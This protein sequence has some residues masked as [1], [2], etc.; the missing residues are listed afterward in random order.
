MNKIER[1][2]AVL[3]GQTPDRLPCTFWYH[4]G[5]QFGP[6]E[7]FARV[8]LSFYEAFDVDILKLMNDYHYRCPAGLDV[9]K[10]AHDLEQVVYIDPETSIAHEQLKAIEIIS[11][12]LQRKA[13]FIDTVFDPWQQ[14][15][16]HVTGEYTHELTQTCPD[17]LLAAL[18]R[19]TDYVIAYAK[20]SLQRGSAGIF[21]A[22]QAS[23]NLVPGGREVY[24]RFIEPQAMRIMDELEG[25]GKLNTLHMCG[26]EIYTENIPQYKFPVLSWADRLPA[27]PSIAEMKQLSSAVM[28][29]GLDQTKLN[30]KSWEMSKQNTIQA[31]KEC[32]KTRSI[33]ACGCSCPPEMETDI[34]KK[35]VA[36]VQQ[37]TL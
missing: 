2:D 18:D 5:G 24:A 33:F 34:Y 19:V 29:A 25:A 36:M 12:R 7:D 9:V 3:A 32:G 31:L 17:E 15:V 11:Q 37:H 8:A 4:F 22:I 27:N 1:V 6:G 20:Q 13:Y 21:L 28:M 26:T 30:R 10:S 23:D 35:I 14:L 16:R